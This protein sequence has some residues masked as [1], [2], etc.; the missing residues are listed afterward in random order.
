MLPEAAVSLSR[1]SYFVLGS[2]LAPDSFNITAAGVK[3]PRI[4]ADAHFPHAY[5]SC[6]IVI[7]VDG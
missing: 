6:I 4:A 2:W 1:R 7:F 5:I 3:S